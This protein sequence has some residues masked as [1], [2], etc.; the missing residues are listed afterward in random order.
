MKEWVT[1]GGG[2]Q[3]CLDDGSLYET[4]RSFLEAPLDRSM[5]DYTPSD[6]DAEVSQAWDALE[7]TKKDTLSTFT[8]QTLRPPTLVT[9]NPRPTA[10][11]TRTRTF[12]NQAADIDHVSAEDLVDNINAMGF[13]AFS[14]VTEEVFSS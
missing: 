7:V 4:V 14:N 8:A 3:D 10:T 9:A 1:T 6:D 13:A 5:P 11:S 12:G 2:A